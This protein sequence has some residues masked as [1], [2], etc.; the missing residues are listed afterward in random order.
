MFL[1]AY[2]RTK[3]GKRHT[4]F[5]LVESRRT[6][7]GPRQRIVAELGELT[8]DQRRRGSGQRSSIPATRTQAVPAVPDDEQPPAG[9]SDVVRIR[10]GRWADECPLSATTG[11]A[12]WRCWAWM[13]S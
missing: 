3:D 13:K 11:V 5:A 9:R 1:R 2:H 4:Y 6:E 7:R 8:P 12:A 10:R